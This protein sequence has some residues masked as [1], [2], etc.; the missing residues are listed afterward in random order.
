MASA[1]TLARI[2]TMSVALSSQGWRDQLGRDLLVLMYRRRLGHVLTP[3]RQLAIT[4]FDPVMA[5][6]VAVRCTPRRSTRTFVCAERCD[7]TAPATRGF[8][9]P[10]CAI[11][12]ASN[13]ESSYRGQHP[14]QLPLHSHPP[15]FSQ[16]LA[17]R[18]L[19]PRSRSPQDRSDPRHRTQLQD[20]TH[21]TGPQPYVV[22]TVPMAHRRRRANVTYPSPA[23]LRALTRA[24]WGSPPSQSL[25][26]LSP[27]VTAGRML[28]WAYPAVF[29][30]SGT[31]AFDVA[32][33]GRG[34]MGTLGG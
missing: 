32:L 3:N 9:F 30:A 11:P 10:Q 6:V 22:P 24:S 7:V 15:L 29:R 2:V 28:A 16:M 5:L 33:G 26:A 13:R 25:P 20:A 14:Y 17:G 18:T 1:P 27:S 23:I 19:G 34:A 8:C 31:D 4:L 21:D 12:R